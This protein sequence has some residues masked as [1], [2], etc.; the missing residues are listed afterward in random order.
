M[1]SEVSEYS[2]RCP[3]AQCGVWTL[4]AVSGLPVKCMDA[5]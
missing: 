4:N 1:L 3:E 5:Q 2:V